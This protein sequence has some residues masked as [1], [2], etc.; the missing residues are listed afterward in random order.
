AYHRHLFGR[1]DQQRFGFRE[2]VVVP[3]ELPEER[4]TL[5]RRH[6]RG[7]KRGKKLR[8]VGPHQDPRAAGLEG[9]R[10][11]RLR[12]PEEQVLR[13]GFENRTRRFH[14]SGPRGTA[15]P[16]PQRAPEDRRYARS[17]TRSATT[18]RAAPTEPCGL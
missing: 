10:E 1:N 12:R 7:R 9:R 15:R 8:V 5:C 3:H 14:V 13:V 6:F 18:P 2:A 17:S 4:A 11:R 16:A